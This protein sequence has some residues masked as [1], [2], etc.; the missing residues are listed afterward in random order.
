MRVRG[1]IHKRARASSSMC[2]RVRYFR[3]FSTTGG[4]SGN[5]RIIKCGVQKRTIPGKIVKSAAS[6]VNAC[7]PDGALLPKSVKIECR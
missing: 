3:R 4:A 2:L 7:L 6:G 1:K 5:D